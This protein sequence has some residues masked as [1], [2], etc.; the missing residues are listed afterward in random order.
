MMHQLLNRQ[1]QELPTDA[2]LVTGLQAHDKRVEE[3]FYRSAK[4]Y[5]MTHFKD[6]FFDE[7]R[8]QEIFQDAVLRL[9]TEI[10]DGRI[11]AAGARLERRQA[12]GLWQPMTASLTT[13]LMA[14]AR[15]SYREVV[16]SNREQ[17][18]GNIFD[19]TPA[20][21]TPLPQ[22]DSADDEADDIR[23]IDECIQEMPPRCLEILTL[24]YYEGRS[25]DEIMTLRGG[26]NESKTGLKTAKY[27]CMQTLKQRVTE[28]RG[29]L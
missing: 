1:R 27:K 3:Q 17:P 7:D 15:N 14:I 13:F 5:F 23:I 19:I 20:D 8:K 10:E 18:C 24:F 4:Q 21:G 9:W 29:Q 2:D 6:I 16:R 11:R 12:S 25:L 22:D 28:R 26:K